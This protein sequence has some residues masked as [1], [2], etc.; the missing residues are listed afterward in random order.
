VL[1]LLLLALVAIAALRRFSRSG[2]GAALQA[3]RDAPLRA[4]ASGLPVQRTK[5]LVLLQSAAL[6]GLAGGLFAAHKGSVFPSTL[7]VATS[8][9]IL[10]VVL[11]GGLHQ[12]WGALVGALVLVVAA[13]ELGRGFDYWRGALGLLVM[14]IMVWAPSGIL[15]LR[16]RAALGAAHG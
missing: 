9:D 11:L 12:L 2:L 10:L 15:G 5:Y 16:R 14:A 1:L 13:S 7:S 3:V 6:A 8:V 4:H